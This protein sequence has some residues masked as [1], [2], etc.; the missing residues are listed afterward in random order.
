MV[1][2][3][4]AGD[5]RA[6]SEIFRDE[7]ADDI[8]LEALL[9]VDDVVRDSEVLGHAAGVVHVVERAAAA[10]LRRVG[11]AMLAGEAGLIPK[12]QGEA[13]HLGAFV[14]SGEDRRDGRGVDSSGHGDGDGLVLGHGDAYKFI[15][16]LNEFLVE[17]GRAP[18]LAK[19][20]ELGQ[21]EE[22]KKQWR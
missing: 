10:R 1:V 3:E 7:G 14:E 19:D 8:L 12:L 15:F 5:R 22:P 4:R 9:L 13:D 20:L 11:N 21:G 6:A 17:N 16:A 18:C 2:A